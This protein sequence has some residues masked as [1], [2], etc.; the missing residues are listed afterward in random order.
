MSEF[1]RE[2]AGNG[3][4]IELHGRGLAGSERLTQRATHTYHKCGERGAMMA[5]EA[6]HA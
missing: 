5:R 2:I 4:S 6:C 1:V 3:A